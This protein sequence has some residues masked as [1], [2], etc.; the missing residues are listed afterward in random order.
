MKARKMIFASD[1]ERGRIADFLRR[2]ADVIDGRCPSCLTGYG[3]ALEEIDRLKIGLRQGEGGE[4][5]LKIK[6]RDRRQGAADI[7]TAVV[8][9]AAD[10]A[11]LH[12][13]RQLKRRMKGT[14]ATLS[15]EIAEGGTVAGATLA[16]FL[17]DSREMVGFAG[18]GDE[19]Y[20]GYLEACEA[21]AAACR[22][23]DAEAMRRGLEELVARKR[24]CHQKFK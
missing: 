7:G 13:Y 6:V 8:R 9:E 18:F 12:A 19:F 10:E 23:G 5:E 2:I 15:R 16:S 24:S 3:I 22:G 20:P 4:L 14:F 17:A 11:T 1:L 21:L